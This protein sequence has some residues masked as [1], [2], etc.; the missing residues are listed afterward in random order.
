MARAR[1][2][3]AR[4]RKNPTG[5]TSVSSGGSP[6]SPEEQPVSGRRHILV[7]ILCGGSGSGLVA[8][9]SRADGHAGQLSLVPADER[10]QEAGGRHRRADHQRAFEPS[11]KGLLQGCDVGRRRRPASRRAR[12]PPRPAK[13]APASAT[14][15]LWPTTRPVAS[16]PEASPCLPGGTAF[17]S[18]RAFGVWNM[19][20]PTPARTDT[21]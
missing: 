5:R 6:D 16:R 4:F 12:D 20:W 21:R 11:E 15:R 7:P 10:G 9:S 17:I 14:L 19:P 18:A 1:G 8:C 13:M 2:R 3:R